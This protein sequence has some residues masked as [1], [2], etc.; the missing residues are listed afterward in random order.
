MTK[1]REE[2]KVLLLQIREEPRVRQEE[3]ESFAR[4]SALNI[5]QITVHSVFD[6]PSF[7]TSLVSTNNCN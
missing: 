6:Q 5:E 7:V 4:Y 1:R 2:L 3:L